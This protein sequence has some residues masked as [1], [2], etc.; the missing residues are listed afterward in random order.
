[1]H[2]RN[3]V[4]RQIRGREQE[5]DFLRRVLDDTENGAGGRHVLTGA[6]G[7]GKSQLLRLVVG[8]A[9]KRGLAVAAREA[10]RLDQAA[11]LVT[12]AGALRECRPETSA[13]AW[14]TQHGPELDTLYRLRTSLERAASERPLLVVIDDA[15]WMDE[16]S[17]L[18]IRELVPALA[19]SPVR[20]LF[21]RR[22]PSSED[23]GKPG[24]ELLRWLQRDGGS[25]II[26]G[27]LGD[28]ALAQLSADLVD[29]EVDDT[30][31]ALVD[32]C[33]GN[34]L[35]TE[36][37]I[38]A[39]LATR[40]LIVA[41]GVGSVVGDA[42]PSSLVDSVREVLETLSQPAGWLL[43]A[44][45]VFARPFHPRELARLTARDATELF[46][47]IDEAMPNFLVE[48]S[49]GAF[50]FT[51]DLVRQAV[52]RMLPRS[53]REQL[54]REIAAITRDTGRPPLEIAE[55]QL[56][57]GESGAVEA[58]NLVR[59]VAREIARTAPGAAA[60]VMLRALKAMGSDDAGRPAMIAD[61]V[62]LLASAA[63][64][65]EARELGTAALDAGL[66]PETEALLLLGLA[67]ACKHSGLNEMTVAYANHGLVDE[68]VSDGVRARLFA[69]RA[70]ALC[71]LGRLDA[72]DA[73]GAQADRLG[74]TAGEYGAAVF[75]LAGRSLVAATRGRLNAALTHARSATAL[76]DRHQEEARLRHPRIWLGAA[77]TVLDDFDEAEGVLREGRRDADQTGSAWT[78]PLWY[79]FQA[80]LLYARGRIEEAVVEAETGAAVAEQHAANALAMPLLGLL[81][82][83]AVLGGN[84]DRAHKHLDHVRRLAADGVTAVAED[85]LW[86]E[87]VLQDAS[88]ASATAYSLL[89]DFYPALLERPAL[90]AAD[91]L[92]AAE[93]VRIA[94]DTG[95]GE[96][97]AL[98]VRAARALADGN[99]GSHA[100]AGAAAHAEG[101]LRRD[102]K[103]LRRAAEEF[104][105]AGRP[106]AVAAAL[107]D[108][109]QVGRGIVP[110]ET[111]RSL[112]GEA[113]A[114]VTDVGAH[115]A[116][117][118]IRKAFGAPA[119]VPEP[120]AQP[121]LPQLTTAQRNVAVQVGDGLT[122][123]EIAEN[124][125]ISRHTVDSHLRNI[126][127]K[128]GLRRRS[129]LAALVARECQPPG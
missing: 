98:A 107:E 103:R 38:K 13:F 46:P 84:L 65:A 50:S 54:H 47:L 115:R 45:S 66:D 77:L 15:Q 6:P 127:A 40:Q 33:G 121:C 82:R 104:R 83:L 8:L 118:R 86:A 52:Y 19:S 24:H 34:P 17:A 116:R 20:W 57:S 21:A 76:A 30:V 28:E 111:V 96:T 99:S 41:D 35:R 67:E 48:D 88:G 12:L 85:V 73:S 94:W 95:H 129:E 7:I 55:H 39:L 58:G 71:Y 26:L 93:L 42:L 9:E 5:I 36:Q 109:A 78:A 51:H 100:A 18:A 43:R 69:V 25:D 124:L 22:P 113:L 125:H 63:R 53:M 97:A 80:S 49:E 92:A 117:D 16:L 74:R 68:R 62:G 64:L 27:P 37:L 105:R 79:H 59:S 122:N 10:F 89:H 56:E 29:A 126:F 4:T 128:L 60:D 23:R 31:L 106:V 123:S 110:E 72:A 81:M 90:I 32:S 114:I 120:E 119:T 3:D 70:H 2:S 102:F 44:A 11:P 14:L 1:M 61:T 87:A 101:L 112:A 91:P 75:G 108:A